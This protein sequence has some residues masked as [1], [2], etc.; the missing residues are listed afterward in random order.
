MNIY[1]ANIPFSAAEGDVK[2][3]FAPYGRVISVKII[4]DKETGKSRGF[5][6]VVM[7][8][9]E[10]ALKAIQALNGSD[11]LG[12]KLA[13]SEARPKDAKSDN[14]NTKKSNPRS[15]NN[16]TV[17]ASDYKA[18]V[19]DFKPNIST[20]PVESKPFSKSEKNTKKDR[21]ER[22]GFDSEKKIKKAAKPSKKYNVYEDDEDDLYYR[23]GKN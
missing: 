12:K 1:I 18:P 6:F 16:A 21:P 5:G 9:D 14:N 3:L 8:N 23:I 4:Q 15:S 10:E 13:V 20:G 19:N 2:G 22:D 7:Q 11:Y 17:R